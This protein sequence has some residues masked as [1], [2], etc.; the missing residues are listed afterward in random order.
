METLVRLRCWGFN[1]LGAGCSERLM[2]Q[3]LAH[4]EFIAFGTQWASQGDEFQI[5]PHAGTPCSAFPNAFHPDF[6]RFCVWLAHRACSPSVGEPT[7]H[8]VSHKTG[9]TNST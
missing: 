4:T 8:E 3:G 7:I 9:F 1:L 6:E 2:R 5:T